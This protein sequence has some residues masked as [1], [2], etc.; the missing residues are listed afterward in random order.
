MK[1]LF[2][3]SSEEKQ[4]ILEMHESATKKNYLSEQAAQPTQQGRPTAGG[5][6]VGDKTYFFTKILGTNPQDAQSKID[7][8]INW[9]S[10]QNLNASL[11]K[12][13]GLGSTQG[14]IVKDPN[15]SDSGKN[16]EWSAMNLIQDYLLAILMKSNDAAGVCNGTIVINNDIVNTAHANYQHPDNKSTVDEIYQYFKGYTTFHKAVQKVAQQQIKKTAPNVCQA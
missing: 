3:I 6:K 1:K 7:T 9:Q 8:F 10:G 14:G 5:L 12:N 2:E 13:I 11:F 15:R 16:I 4:R